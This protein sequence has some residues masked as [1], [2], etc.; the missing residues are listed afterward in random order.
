MAEFNPRVNPSNDPNYIGYSRPISQP[1]ADKT[2]GSLFS[3]VGNVLEAGAKGAVEVVTQDAQK[4]AYDFVDQA[5]NRVIPALEKE[6]EKGSQPGARAMGYAAE[7]A[8]A[9]PYDVA[10]AGDTASSYEGAHQGRK[11]SRT[12]YEAALHDFSKSLRA[13][14]PGFRE[15]VDRAIDKATTGGRANELIDKMIAG[16]N[17]DRTR[18][19]SENARVTR[20][21]VQNLKLHPTMPTLLEAWE[22]NPTE[23]LKSR[24]YTTIGRAQN[25]KYQAEVDREEFTTN[26]N[27]LETIQGDAKRKFQTLAIAEMN[28]TLEGGIEVGAG[29]SSPKQLSDTIRKIQTGEIPLNSPA[30]QQLPSV[31]KAWKDQYVRRMRAIGTEG[32][33]KSYAVALNGKDGN[34]FE[35]MNKIIAEQSRWFD[36]MADSITKK[37]WNGAMDAAEM[38]KGIAADEGL[39]LLRDP[40]TRPYFTM[41]AGVKAVVGEHGWD[42]FL[43]RATVEG[44]NKAVKS[45]TQRQ[46]SKMWTQPD[47]RRTGYSFTAN[48]AFEEAKKEKVAFPQVYEKFLSQV[49]NIADPQWGTDAGKWNLIQSFYRPEN[50]KFI[51]NF[52]KDYW[53][54]ARRVQVPGTMKVFRQMTSDGILNEAA[55]IDQKQPGTYATVV[56]WAEH[57]FVNEILPKDI[58]DLA[59]YDPEKV[60]NVRIG[61]DPESHMLSMGWN[62]P[63][64]KPPKSASVNDIRQHDAYRATVE[65]VNLGIERLAK[66]YDRATGKDIDATI[67]TLLVAKGF[68]PIPKSGEAVGIPHKI[69]QE[70]YNARMKQERIQKMKDNP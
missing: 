22:K 20:D 61:Y 28:T 36:E 6:Y 10:Q 57:S 24:I 68:S 27:N 21:I 55:R 62:T 11:L 19:R 18:S 37:D 32:G 40:D 8:P 47:L 50:Y 2:W 30:V 64:G 67:M 44:M 70:I 12:Y 52:E 14:Y 34:G 35:T 48:D 23:E 17:E 33:R 54:P 13:R 60:K 51:Q 42:Q 25:K 43:Q 7:D 65:R 4:R 45:Y 5:N 15:E 26:Q 16:I 59:T 63:N 3:G 66:V 69:A 29:I 38:I 39:G 41:R 31:I 49:D 56:N 9:L 58:A 1:D 46:I 53:D